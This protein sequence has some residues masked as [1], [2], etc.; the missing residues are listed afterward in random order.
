MVSGQGLP[1][2]GQFRAV[3]NT[4][5][6]MKTRATA[7]AFLAATF[8]FSSLGSSARAGYILTWAG[9]DH[10]DDVLD[11]INDYNSTHNPD[12]PT[13]F[14]QLSVKTDDGGAYATL[15]GAGFS[16]WSDAAGT[17]PINSIAQLHTEATSF[18]TYS[19]VTQ[20][21]YYT[22]KASNQFEL[23]QYQ[24]GVN[25]LHYPAG[26]PAISHITFWAGNNPALVDTTPEP[27]SMVLLCMGGGMIAVGRKLR[28]RKPADVVS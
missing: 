9:N 3:C 19:G 17:I 8:V 10:H 24:P 22:V 18:F 16:F 12:L 23:F 14:T 20:L 1:D 5:S 11:A 21:L 6:A 27:A 26:P 25:E 15:T 13:V 2:T 4:E 7:A 28:A